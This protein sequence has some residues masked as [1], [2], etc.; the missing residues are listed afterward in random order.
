MAATA[1]HSKNAELA[2]QIP[3]AVAT[4]GNIELLDELCSPDVVDHS[5]FG[6]LEGREAL[7]QQ[8]RSIRDAFTDFEAAVIETVSEGDVVAMRIRLTGRHVGE[9]VGIPATGRSFDVE[10]MVFTRFE[11]GKIVERWVQPDMLGM[12]DQLGVVESPIDVPD[13]E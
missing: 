4:K 13:L 5:P 6:D 9:F 1:P 8:M 10:N 12:L 7:G 11:D 3:E 2:R